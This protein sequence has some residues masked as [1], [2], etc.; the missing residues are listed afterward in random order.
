MNV[1]AFS[2][3]PPTLP[4]PKWLGHGGVNIS[5]D[6]RRADING[7]PL[8]LDRRTFALLYFFVS[9]KGR[10]LSRQQIL[11]NVWGMDSRHIE[12]RTIDVYVRRVR[13][14]LAAHGRVYLLRTVRG[15]GYC[16]GG[17]V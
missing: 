12:D 6:A 3:C 7:E 9:N 14:V 17:E 16:F 10:A 2:T 1:Q 13:E 5:W 4:P 11:D 15:C 8:T